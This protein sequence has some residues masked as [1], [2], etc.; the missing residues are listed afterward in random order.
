MGDVWEKLKK[1][2]ETF[3]DHDWGY[4][5]TRCVLIFISHFRSILSIHLLMA[6]QHANPLSEAYP[7]IYPA[8]IQTLVLASD[9]LGREAYL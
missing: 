5:R 1:Q 4:F 3:I 7:K 9:D 2:I 8:F 6:K